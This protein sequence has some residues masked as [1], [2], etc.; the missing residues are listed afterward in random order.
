MSFYESSCTQ[1]EENRDF[2]RKKLFSFLKS[3]KTD[4]QEIALLKKGDKVCTNDVD[5]A[6][7]LNAQFQSVSSIRTPLDLKKLC[8]TTMLNE[9]TS[10][11]NL[12]P[13]RLQWKFPIMQ[14]IKI[15]TA[16]VS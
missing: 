5:Q 11:V 7:L 4:T 14:D 3:S 13:E 6:N 9:A 8:H 1:G 12:L 2:S 16:G 15:S 10:L